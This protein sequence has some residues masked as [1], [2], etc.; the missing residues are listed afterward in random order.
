LETKE[1]EGERGR[2]KERRKGDRE[3]VPCAK[4]QKSFIR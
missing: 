4:R 3:I 2:K 1:I